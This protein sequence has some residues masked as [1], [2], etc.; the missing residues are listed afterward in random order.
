MLARMR[1]LLLVIHLAVLAALGPLFLFTALGLGLLVSTIARTQLQAIQFAFMIMLPSIL[2]SGFVF[3]REAMPTPI[4][5]VTFAIPVTYFIEILR[6]II[7]RSA[8]LPDLLPHV[9]GL[10]VCCAAIL[11]L[12]VARFRKQLD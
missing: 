1:R 8:G 12:S 4:Y 7:L 11:G 9:V 2:L 10:A 3:P 5:V 6:G